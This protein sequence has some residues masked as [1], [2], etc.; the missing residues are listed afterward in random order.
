MCAS[1]TRRGSGITLIEMMTAVA[2]VAILLAVAA[3]NMM[4]FFVRNRL[5]AANNAFVAAL[6]EARSEAVKRGVP[7]TIRRCDV[8][9]AA[10]GC[11][12]V[13]ASKEWTKGWYLFA[14]VDGNRTLDNSPGTQEQ[15]IRVGQPLNAPLTMRSSARLPDAVQFL[16][17]GRIY[18]PATASF[19]FLICYDG[20]VVQNGR[21]RSRAILVNASGRVRAGLD[22]V[23]GLPENEAGTDMNGDA[24]CSDPI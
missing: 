21:S 1:S 3:P 22:S 2:I 7:V 20:H 6:N 11:P 16:P 18:S 12:Q 23:T 15:V 5:D 13:S 10:L 14:D 17:D 9:N 24:Y 19:T 4:E 8:E